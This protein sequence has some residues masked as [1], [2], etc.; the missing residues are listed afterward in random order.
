MSPFLEGNIKIMKSIE[1]LTRSCQIV[2][3]LGPLRGSAEDCCM[4]QLGQ[5]L[6]SM[7]SAGQMLVWY[8]NAG[9]DIFRLNM[10]FAALG[11]SYGSLEMKYLSWLVKHHQQISSIGLLGDLPGPKIRLSQVLSKTGGQVKVGDIIILNFGTQK[12]TRSAT[13]I[14]AVSVNGQ[15][16]SL[17]VA[18]IDGFPNISTYIKHCADSIFFVGDGEVVLQPVSANDDIITCMVLEAGFL[19]TG[20]GLTI[21]EATIDVPTFQEVDQKALDFLMENARAVL[22]HVAVSFVQDHRDIL[23]VK[24]HLYDKWARYER[25]RMPKVIAKIETKTACQDIDNILDVADGIMIARGDLAPQ[26]GHANVPNIQKRLISKCNQAGVPV[27]TA[28]QMLGSMEQ[29]K[30]PSRAEVS[31]VFNAVVDGTDAVMLSGETSM[32][33]YPVQS[34]KMMHDIVLEAEQYRLQHSQ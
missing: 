4:D 20:K 3:T 18:R 32:G 15:P 17:Q 10:S 9:V 34:I 6:K 24:S 28:T 11:Q 26:V 14:G 29:N 2:A 1:K 16:F 27:I 25:G 19:R 22:S 23:K 31:D 33:K 5:P 30:Y 21:K 8:I 13:A 12:V 7:V